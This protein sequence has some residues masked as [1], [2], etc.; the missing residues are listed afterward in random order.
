MRQSR[1]PQCG[2]FTTVKNTSYASD[3]LEVD[4]TTSTTSTATL[5]VDQERSKVNEEAGLLNLSEG[6]KLEHMKKH[7]QLT[8]STEPLPGLGSLPP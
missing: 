4:L 2:S 1:Y 6:L 5:G 3:V 8:T 7:D